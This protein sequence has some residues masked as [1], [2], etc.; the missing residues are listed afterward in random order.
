MPHAQIR[1][2]FRRV[3]QQVRAASK[4]ARWASSHSAPHLYRDKP[5]ADFGF[6]LLVPTPRG[7]AHGQGLQ[8]ADQS[9]ALSLTS[10]TSTPSR[11]V[12]ACAKLH[13]MLN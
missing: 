3:P 1:A 2:G 13:E 9:I 6:V 7:G 12:N 10:A 11:L 4:P 8:K 5:G